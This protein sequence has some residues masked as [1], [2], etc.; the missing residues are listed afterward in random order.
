MKRLVWII[1]ASAGTAIFVAGWAYFAMRDMAGVRLNTSTPNIVSQHA[2]SPIV[3]GQAVVEKPNQEGV[4]ATNGGHVND[5]IAEFASG[6]RPSDWLEASKAVQRCVMQE[7]LKRDVPS[8][9]MN[10]VIKMSRGKSVDCSSLPAEYRR[11]YLVW[12]SKAV[13]S[14]EPGAA[15]QHWITGPNGHPEDLVTRK[16]DLLVRAWMQQTEV[17]LNRAAKKGDVEAISGLSMIYDNGAIVD[18]DS[19]KSA[20]FDMV[21]AKIREAQT[22]KSSKVYER[23]FEEN[24]RRLGTEKMAEIENEAE[25]YYRECCQHA[26]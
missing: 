7:T 17:L 11:D 13:E 8:L 22:G 18:P 16:D 1:S 6:A 10:A 9:A 25:A 2:S 3:L 26:H 20:M 21:L 5:W 14:N 24:R 23:L 15:V 12:L 4:N 19:A